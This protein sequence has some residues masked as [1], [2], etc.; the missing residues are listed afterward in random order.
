MAHIVLSSFFLF[1]SPTRLIGALSPDS[2]TGMIS[3]LAVATTGPIHRSSGSSSSLKSLGDYVIIVLCRRQ[4]TGFGRIA[5][6]VA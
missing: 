6:V 3:A 4:R 1:I 5:S 2:G